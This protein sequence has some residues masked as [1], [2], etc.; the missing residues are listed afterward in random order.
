M[1]LATYLFVELLHCRCFF[2]RVLL[3]RGKGIPNK[4]QKIKRFS[5]GQRCKACS[6]FIFAI[7][8]AC[9]LFFFL[10]WT[11]TICSF[12]WTCCF[13]FCLSKNMLHTSV[14][15]LIVNSDITINFKW[16][17]V[18]QVSVCFQLLRHLDAP[19]WDACVPVLKQNTQLLNTWRERMILSNE[20]SLW[21][22]P[23][24]PSLYR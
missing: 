10:N 14:I 13:A 17:T 20:T 24:K 23:R 5:V 21:V 11:Q 18:F 16:K 2:K 8:C 9:F 4:R 22:I 12:I 15:T 3:P 1:T 7:C 6:V 19:T